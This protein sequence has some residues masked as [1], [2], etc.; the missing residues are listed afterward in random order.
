MVEDSSKEKEILIPL[1]L[2]EMKLESS[3]VVL[4]K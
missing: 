1:I 4:I 3:F 2:R